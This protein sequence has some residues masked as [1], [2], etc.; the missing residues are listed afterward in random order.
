[1][2]KSEIQRVVGGGPLRAIFPKSDPCNFFLFER[3][4]EST[5]RNLMMMMFLEMKEC[6]LHLSLLVC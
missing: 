2:L 5:N 1:M 6:A 3:D 4:F